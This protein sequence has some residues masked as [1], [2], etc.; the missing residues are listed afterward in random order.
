MEFTIQDVITRLHGCFRRSEQYI[1]ELQK[2]PIANEEMISFIEY[3]NGQIV[4]A[5]E[6]LQV[7]FY[8]QLVC[9]NSY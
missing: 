5:K 4:S 6:Y 8:N 3:Q 1:L 9:G 7:V 2:E